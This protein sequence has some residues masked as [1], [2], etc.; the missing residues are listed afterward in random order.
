MHRDLIDGGRVWRRRSRFDNDGKVWRC[1]TTKH[2]EEVSCKHQPAKNL[3]I[4]PR[5]RIPAHCR[6]MLSSTTKPPDLPEKR[7]TSRARPS[8]KGR[9]KTLTEK[10]CQPHIAGKRKTPAIHALPNGGVAH[11]GVNASQERE[12]LL[13]AHGL[14]AQIWHRNKNQHRG[15]KWWKWVAVL[16]RAVRDL[17]ELTVVGERNVPNEGG[18]GQKVGEAGMMRKRMELERAR[19]EQKGQ[20]EGWLREVVLGR[21]WL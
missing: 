5:Q 2:V 11:A 1:L 20:V 15:Q 16:K 7:L 6:V 10:K 8:N 14:I 9:A 4:P 13:Q 18:G 19:R 12:E 3:H 17:V 21:C